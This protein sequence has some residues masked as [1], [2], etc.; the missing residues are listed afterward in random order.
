MT[1]SVSLY[2][3]KV[4]GGLM[5]SVWKPVQQF[6]YISKT[7]NPISMLHTVI[8][9]KV[10]RVWTLSSSL[11]YSSHK[12]FHNS[13]PSKFNTMTVLEGKLFPGRH[14]NNYSVSGLFV[15]ACFS[16]WPQGGQS[17]QLWK[18]LILEMAGWCLV[19][20]TWLTCNRMPLFVD[21]T[22]QF[23]TMCLKHLPVVQ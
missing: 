11:S 18:L 13:A 3:N 10:C 14:L 1:I 17:E 23:S 6:L 9:E 15:T 22:L 20:V 12:Y 16:N 21:Q 8:G 5:K 7:G 4:L 2:S 19:Q